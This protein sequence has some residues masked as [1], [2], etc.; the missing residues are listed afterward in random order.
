MPGSREPRE[1]TSGN[2]R[3][4]RALDEAGN[5][6]TTWARLLVEDRPYLARLLDRLDAAQLGE[7]D[8]VR[9]LCLG[10]DRKLTSLS[11]L[12]WCGDFVREISHHENRLRELTEAV[13]PGW[14]GGGCGV[15]G[16]ATY[17]VPGLTWV[18]CRSCGA[19]THASAHLE[20][21]RTEARPWVDRPMRIAEAVVALVDGQT[22]AQRL[23]KR[24]SKWG[25]RGAIEVVRE[26]D[27]LPKNYRFGEVLDMLERD[28]RAGIDRSVDKAS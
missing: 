27:H 11:T 19:T 5:A 1:S 14:Y 4:S 2:D 6:L 10:F 16:Y 26:H 22:D 15:C 8:T 9:W 23:H 20:A 28:T 13:A 25:E 21:V 7:A 18:T 24:I 3:V 12:D 17:V